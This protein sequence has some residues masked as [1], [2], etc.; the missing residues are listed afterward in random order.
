MVNPSATDKDKAIVISLI[1]SVESLFPFLPQAAPLTIALCGKGGPAC[2]PENS[3]RPEYN[4]I[5]IEVL[6]SPISQY[7]KVVGLEVVSSTL[8]HEYG[9]YVFLQK[10]K[11]DIKK[12]ETL[13]NM[14]SYLESTQRK[15]YA[16][17]AKQD[18]I[19]AKKLKEEL[20]SQEKNATIASDLYFV[21]LFYQEL[22]SDFL[23]AVYYENP[24]IVCLAAEGTPNCTLDETK[25]RKFSVKTSVAKANE[26]VEKNRMGVQ[27]LVLIPARNSIWKKYLSLRRQGHSKSEILNRVLNVMI[28]LSAKKMFSADKL[29][30]DLQQM[31]SKLIAEINKL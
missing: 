22:Y 20:E 3:Y 31:N 16:A 2:M 15:M 30:P 7:D 25:V 13:L 27:H 12:Y 21:S 11:K 17:N 18:Q 10:A 8:V 29:N 1:Q 24:D 19:E 23:A 28:A 6:R 9:H 26:M 14:M 4:R 5:N